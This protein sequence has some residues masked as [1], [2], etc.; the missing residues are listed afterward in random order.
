[1]NEKKKLDKN[2]TENTIEKLHGQT[3]EK[4]LLMNNRTSAA[5]ALVN[6]ARKDSSTAVRFGR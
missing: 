6:E 3:L 1:M 5:K 2:K 4:Q